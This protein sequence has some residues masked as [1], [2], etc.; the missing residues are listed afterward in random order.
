MKRFKFV[1]FLCL[2][3]IISMAT[4]HAET[5]T[6][7]AYQDFLKLRQETRPNEVIPNTEK[8]KNLNAQGEEN[9]LA[10]ET[11]VA[12]HW[13][14]GVGLCSR[15]LPIIAMP[16]TVIPVIHLNYQKYRPQPWSL[17]EYSFELGMST[18]EITLSQWNWISNGT[19]LALFK[20]GELAW[21]GCDVREYM[22][23]KDQDVVITGRFQIVRFLN[24]ATNSGY[25]FYDM[26]GGV[27]YPI[28]L[29]GG[30]Y[31]EPSVFADFLYVSSML[32]DGKRGSSSDFLSEINLSFKFD[33]N[34]YF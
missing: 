27:G 30:L 4:L 33:M 13:G 26:G 18:S 32:L 11:T 34:Y 20:Q 22:G 16:Q 8:K 19:K 31:L 3:T 7:N 9:P 1:I 15:G 2:I 25:L 17:D 28:K 29:A 10:P 12:Q 24:K 5:S 14:I 23:V 21:F 6:A